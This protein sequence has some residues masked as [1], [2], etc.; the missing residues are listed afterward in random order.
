MKLFRAMSACISVMLLCACA[1]TSHQT[2][3]PNANVDRSARKVTRHVATV[4][5]MPPLHL[6]LNAK[7]YEYDTL[8]V[9]ASNSDVRIFAAPTAVTSNSA[10]VHVVD[11]AGRTFDFPPGSVV[12]HGTAHYW[13]RPGRSLPAFLAHARFVRTITEANAP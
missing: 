6:A 10:G 7:E 1:V 11:A 3:L 13:L 5:T 9:R 2:T 8:L 4:A 12:R